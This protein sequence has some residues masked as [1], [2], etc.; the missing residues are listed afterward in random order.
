MMIVN[1]TMARD[2][3]PGQ[4]AL[5]QLAGQRCGS[6][7]QLSA[8]CG[9]SLLRRAPARK[10]IC[11]FAKRNDYLRRSCRAK[12]PLERRSSAPRLREA[13]LPLAPD[14]PA[15]N[16]RPL[17]ALVDKAVSPRRFVVMLLGGFAVFA[18]I[19]AA[20]GIYAVISYSVSL[21]TQEIGIRMA[22]GATASGVQ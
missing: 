16:L 1:E 12:F 3:W 15:A 5:G 20:L 13:L 18:L 9:T 21:R 22:L 10:C 11:P 4:D 2:L 7:R 6:S 17:Q 8:T 14:L 19:L